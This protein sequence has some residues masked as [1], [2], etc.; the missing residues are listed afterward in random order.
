MSF[1]L[2]YA[3]V[4]CGAV[5]FVV[6]TPTLQCTH[7]GE[8]MNESTPWYFVLAILFH[9]AERIDWF[10]HLFSKIDPAS[11]ESVEKPASRDVQSYVLKHILSIGACELPHRERLEDCDSVFV[12]YSNFIIDDTVLWK[13]KER[14]IFSVHK[15]NQCTHAHMYVRIM[16]LDM[17][18]ILD[19]LFVEK[20]RP[21]KSTHGNKI[22]RRNEAHR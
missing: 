9:S 19:Y 7:Y 16:N 18:T 11:L 20:A 4:I 6:Y 21:K 15:S 1:R 5:W 14:I 17:S 10:I 12:S 8:W 3:V 22:W 13:N 2:C